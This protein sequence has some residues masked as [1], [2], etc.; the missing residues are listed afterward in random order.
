MT[1]DG[2]LALGETPDR[3]ELIDGVVVMSP[4]PTPRHQVVALLVGA[5]L[6]ASSRAVPGAIVVPDV[7]LLLGS[8]G[9]YRPDLMVYGPGRFT[10]L[11]ERL[12]DAPD[13][14]VEITSPGSKSFDLITK[15]DDYE[16]FGVGEYWV[17]DP[18]TLGVRVWRRAGAQLVEGGVGVGR[19]EC[20][21]V[22]GL[23]LDLGRVRS[24]LGQV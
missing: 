18:E 5:E 3:Y 19:I 22:P 17:I 6:L 8:R 10:R 21:S 14:V 16:A 1:A 4:S 2:F 12:T 20:V 23:S 7:D 15:R 24:G 9:V 11:P 13:L